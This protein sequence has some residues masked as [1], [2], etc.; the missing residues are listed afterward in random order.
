MAILIASIFGVGIGSN[1]QNIGLNTNANV[2]SNIN[3]CTPVSE[4]QWTSLGTSGPGPR[5]NDSMAYGST[6]VGVIMFGGEVFS[7]SNITYLNQTWQYFSGNWINLTGV[8]APPAMIGA[9]MQYDPSGGYI[10]LFGGMNGTTY[11]NETWIFTGKTWSP[12]NFTTH[13]SSR[14]FASMSYSPYLK[15]IIMFGGVGPNGYL[16][17]TWEYKNGGW[18]NITA[19][20]KNIPS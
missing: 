1:N 20:S 7:E 12:I 5:S 15:A 16:N 11:F 9:S 2:S 19:N 3:Y 13:P 17:S 8:N 4:N 6:S 14:A 10:L 18:I